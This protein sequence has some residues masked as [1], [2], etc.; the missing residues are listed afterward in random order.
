MATGI[1]RQPDHGISA[2]N[3]P[4]FY[5]HFAYHRW[6]YHGLEFTVVHRRLSLL[7]WNSPSSLLFPLNFTMISSLV[8]SHHLC[9]V[10]RSS[11]SHL[12]GRSTYTRLSLVNEAGSG[13]GRLKHCRRW[14]CNNQ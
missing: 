4:K 7:T 2:Y 3:I 12:P 9:S 13:I 11:S 14:T 10:E 5:H 8:S 1:N 6:T